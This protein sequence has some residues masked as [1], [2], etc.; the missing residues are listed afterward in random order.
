MK[1]RK[2]RWMHKLPQVLLKLKIPT[3]WVEMM[4]KDTK[5][6]IHIDYRKPDSSAGKAD[7]SV[8]ENSICDQIL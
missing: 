3:C 1:E 7:K 5:E 4:N 8:V 2:L 6:I